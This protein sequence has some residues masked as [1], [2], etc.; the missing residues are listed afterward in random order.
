MKGK[1]TAA[2]ISAALIA[3]PSPVLAA[4]YQGQ[5]IDGETF[6]A[7]AYSYETGG[8]FDIQVRF[9]KRRAT[10][11]F[12]NGGRQTIR[13]NQPVI[14]NPDHIDGWHRGF[15]TIGGLFSIGVTDNNDNNLQP[16]RPR[17]LEGFWRISLKDDPV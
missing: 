4:E 11:Y 9:K 2:W 16:P 14:T 5:N 13:L 10:M 3:S 7:T 1:W 15:L 8:L 12:V 17:P 6:E